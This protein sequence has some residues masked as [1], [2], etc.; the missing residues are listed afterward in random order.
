[1]EKL[2][3]VTNEERMERVSAEEGE[4]TCMRFRNAVMVALSAFESGG[5]GDSV[6]LDLDVGGS[7]WV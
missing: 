1:M 7:W 4:K 6:D 5:F 3:D 2:K